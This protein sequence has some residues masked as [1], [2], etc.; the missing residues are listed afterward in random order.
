[1]Y[2]IL[3]LVGN[4]YYT[5]PP[6]N[7]RLETLKIVFFWILCLFWF[8][9]HWWHIC[10]P[11]IT[12]HISRYISLGW[13]EYTIMLSSFLSKRNILVVYICVCVCSFLFLFSKL[14]IKFTAKFHRFTAKF[15]SIYHILFITYYLKTY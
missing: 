5:F 10:G 13:V 2:V 4:I 6:A 11:F 3:I 7:S 9:Q 1:M 15:H 8:Y 12:R 14:L